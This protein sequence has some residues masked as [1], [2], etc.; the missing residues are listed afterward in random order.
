MNRNLSLYAIFALI[1][2]CGLS[3]LYGVSNHARK[4]E[5]KKTID[6]LTRVCEREKEISNTYRQL[7]SIIWL[8]Y[9]NHLDEIEPLRLDSTAVLYDTLSDLYNEQE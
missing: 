6:S 3:I 7:D 1:I 8:N 5:Y 2:C 9:Q 4:C